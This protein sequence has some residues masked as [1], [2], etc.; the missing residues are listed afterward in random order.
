MW[1]DH[2]SVPSCSW[3]QQLT[4]IPGFQKKKILPPI[5]IS[6]WRWLRK[7]GRS[8]GRSTAM[9]RSI[10]HLRPSTSASLIISEQQMMTH[11]GLESSLVNM[12][13]LMCSLLLPT[14]EHVQHLN[15]W[16]SRQSPRLHSRPL[17]FPRLCSRPRRSPCLHHSPCLHCP[18]A[19]HSPHTH[20]LCTIPI[21]FIPL[22]P[23]C[24]SQCII[25]ILRG[26]LW[27]HI[28]PR[29][30]LTPTTCSLGNIFVE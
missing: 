15:R 20:W 25:L 30:W 14:L 27:L 13:S 8:V 16:S 12:L 6:G 21:I 22:Q 26:P 18:H 28:I 1:F 24:L 7:W 3:Q 29:L 9:E 23:L 17:C 10:A 4:M 5:S 19:S 2:S 11:M